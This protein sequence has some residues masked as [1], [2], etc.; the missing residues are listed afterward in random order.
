MTDL[1]LPARTTPHL[2]KLTAA[3][4]NPKASDEDRA[5]L[6]EI[7][8]KYL[9]WAAA[10][11]AVIEGE[12]PR[13]RVHRQAKLFN[14]Y[15]FFVEVECIAR[16]GSTWLKRQKGQLK[17]DN[18][19]IEEFLIHLVHPA[20]LPGFDRLHE[21]T[22]GPNQ[23]FMSMSFR[24]DSLGGLLDQPEVV[25][26]TKDQDFTLGAR[27]HYAVATNALLTD[28]KRGSFVLAVLAA[29]CKVNLDKTMFQEAAGTATR[30][31]QGAP[32][33]KYFVIAEFIDMVPED[34]R[35]TDIDNVFLLRGVRR[36]G[37]SQRGDAEEIARCHKEHPIREDVLWRFVEEMQSFVEAVWFDPTTVLER[38]SFI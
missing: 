23:A 1:E 2:N 24:A 28:A 32:M 12:E 35:L 17:L 33:S 3:A 18:S 16:R 29:E 5:L 36:L 8:K 7:K 34:V 26:K 4:A 9:E 15:K 19:I 13:A 14:E 27:L 30:L 6:E 20:T 11:D 22:V 31:K 37:P 10:L 21:L 25:V 38:G